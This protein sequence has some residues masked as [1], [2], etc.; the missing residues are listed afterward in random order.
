MALW[1]QI[2]AILSKEITLEMRNRYAING[3]LL[4]VVSTV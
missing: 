1:P 2:Q 4:Y 3:I